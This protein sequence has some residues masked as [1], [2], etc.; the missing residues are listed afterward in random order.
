MGTDITCAIDFV[1]AMQ[2]S[3]VFIQVIP[4][5]VITTSHAALER[6]NL[7][8]IPGTL[9][10]HQLMTNSDMEPGTIKYRNVSC[11]CGNLNS[12]CVGHEF[13]EA[14]VLA[15]KSVIVDEIQSN[16]HSTAT[17]T[18]EAIDFDNYL[19]RLESCESNSSLK[20]ACNEI[21][22]EIPPLDVH[23]EAICVTDITQIDPSAQR[24]YPDDTPRSMHPCK[25]TA[26]GNCLP[27]SASV[28]AFNSL[29]RTSEMRVWIIIESE[30]K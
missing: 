13:Q 23:H 1:K 18:I 15:E 6:T 17:A 5:E 28:F 27:S 11:T 22:L 16:I 8:P 3:E 25:S 2:D 12:V 10:L 26:N 7:K 14:S 24:L 21:E 20:T 9:K 29:Q 30:K 4:S 19:S